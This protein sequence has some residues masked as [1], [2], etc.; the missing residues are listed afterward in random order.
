MWGGGGGVLLSTFFQ[1]KFTRS[2]KHWEMLYAHL[3]YWSHRK[4]M[5]SYSPWHPQQHQRQDA[6]NT[7][8][9]LLVIP[10]R[11]SHGPRTDIPWGSRD[12]DRVQIWNWE[13]R[14]DLS[15]FAILRCLSF[16][17]CLHNFIGIYLSAP[18]I[19]SS[20]S[21]IFHLIASSTLQCIVIGW[22]PKYAEVLIFWYTLSKWYAKDDFGQKQ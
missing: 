1:P 18:Q 20:A 4:Y 13:R 16:L 6:S 9:K 21:F 5:T 15:A 7:D 14:M 3:K 2:P 17:I 12:T 22:F 19:F 10:Y 11:K 8:H